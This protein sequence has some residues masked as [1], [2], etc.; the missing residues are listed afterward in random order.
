MAK[1]HA[2]SDGRFIDDY[3]LYLLARASAL[4]SSQFHAELAE[5]GVSVPTW[6]VLA[7]LADGPATV[8]RLARAVML[9]QATLSKAIDR[10]ERD[11]LV[12]R[13]RTGRDRREVTV[14]LTDAGSEM[15]GALIPAAAEHQEKLLTPYDAKQRDALM[16]VL[17]DF[18]EMAERG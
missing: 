3:L 9:K 6:R 14:S 7:V 5:R 18:V 13:E 16:T 8:G 11:G 2:P 15:V 17:R 10:M 12:T 4:A 1:D